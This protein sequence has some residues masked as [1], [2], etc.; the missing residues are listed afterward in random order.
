LLLVIFLVVNVV[1]RGSALDEPEASEEWEF[2]D[3][4]EHF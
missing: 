2:A 1:T 3:N 4:P